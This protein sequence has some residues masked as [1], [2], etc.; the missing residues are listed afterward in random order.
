[1]C[2]AV[3]DV[4][5]HDT[6]VVTRVIADLPEAERLGRAGSPTFLLDG[7]DPFAEPGLAPGLACRVYRTSHGL[8]GLPERDQLH[9]A[10]GA[11]C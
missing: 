11:G 10:L 1:M 3:D 2:R 9:R 8:A 5:L 4:G 7:R 6:Q